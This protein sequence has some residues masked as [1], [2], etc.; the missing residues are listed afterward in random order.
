MCVLG[1][2]PQGLWAERLEWASLEATVTAEVRHR[3]ELTQRSGGERQSPQLLW[4][5]NNNK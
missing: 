2:C 1:R 5:N 3:E 4:S